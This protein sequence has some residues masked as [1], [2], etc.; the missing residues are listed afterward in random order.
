MPK[1]LLADL[2]LLVGDV[3]ALAGFTHAIALDGLGQ[4]DRR[5]PLVLHGRCIG[6]I[7]LLRIVAPSLQPPEVLIRHVGDHLFEFRV[8]AEEML[9]HKG[10]VVGGI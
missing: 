9:A 1:R 8:F 10:A 2:L 4:N 7:D 3:L 5:L 6:R